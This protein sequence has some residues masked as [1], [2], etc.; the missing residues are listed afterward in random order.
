M[1]GKDRPRD[2]SRKSFSRSKS[3]SGNARAGE[4]LANLRAIKSLF[5]GGMLQ[6]L[7]DIRRHIKK[8]LPAT[9]FKFD[10]ESFRMLLVT[11]L[12]NFLGGN[13]DPMHFLEAPFWC[14]TLPSDGVG[15][16]HPVTAF[17]LSGLRS[18]RS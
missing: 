8:L 16:R 9:V 11:N 12:C 13:W 17:M 14:E 2:F 6:S 4:A 15:T 1:P 10:F 18:C 7:E 5:G 3:P